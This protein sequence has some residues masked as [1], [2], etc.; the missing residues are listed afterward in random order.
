MLMK[1]TQYSTLSKSEE[2][3]VEEQL[4]TLMYVSS[5]NKGGLSL[6]LGK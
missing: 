1:S 6:S 3:S 5:G 4:G 2:H